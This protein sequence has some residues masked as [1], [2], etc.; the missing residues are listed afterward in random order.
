VIA[1]SIGE[2]DRDVA[3]ADLLKARV[4]APVVSDVWSPPFDLATAG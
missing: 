1:E 3:I 4:G 2:R